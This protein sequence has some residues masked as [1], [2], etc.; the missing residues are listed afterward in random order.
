[1]MLLVMMVMT[2]SVHVG[3]EA[4]VFVGGASEHIDGSSVDIH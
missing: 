4:K 2:L 3:F 1:M